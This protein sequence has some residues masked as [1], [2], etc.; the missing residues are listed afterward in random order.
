MRFPTKL[1][2][3]FSGN[4]LV[5]SN[6][7]ENANDALQAEI[8]QRKQTEEALR[9]SEERFRIVAESASDLIYEWDIL[10]GRLD[11][12]GNIDEMLGYAPGEFP[13]T[14][15]V[16]EEIIYPD[17]QD[18]VMT[19][20]DRHLKTK[21][22]FFE[23]YRVLRKDG[24]ILY[25]TDRGKALRDEKGTPYRW[26]GAI[27]NITER[28]QTEEAL[29]ENEEHFRLLAESA[30][31][32]II[33]VD[34]TGRIIFWNKGA[35]DVFGYTAD[36]AL[37]MLFTIVVPERLRERHQ[38]HIENFISRGR[39][40]ILE[41]AIEGIGV[42][43]DGRELFFETSNSLWKTKEGVFLTA[44]IHDI[45]DRK[46][47]ENELKGTKKFLENIF[48][49]T[50]DGIMISDS[51]GYIVRINRALEEMLGFTQ[52]ELIG[53]HTAELAPQTEKQKQIGEKLLTDL[54]EKGFIKNF[55]TAWLRKDGSLCPVELN[56]TMLKDK[57][58]NITEAVSAIRDITERKKME[59]QI[60]RAEKLRSL[61]ELSGGVAHDFNNILAAILGRTQL[62]KR[63]IETTSQEKQIRGDSA[64]DLKNGLEII[65]R[66]ALDGAETV[67]RIQEFSRK[68]DE[69]HG[70]I[71]S[72][73]T[74][75]D[76]NKV[77]NDALEF[78]Q[79]RWKDTAESK[80]IKIGIERNLSSV[81][82]I[83]G[84]ASELREVLTNILNNALDAMPEGGEIRI[85]SLRENNTVKIKIG[86]TGI[87]IPSEIK[88]SIYDPFFTTKGPQ[89]TGLG[90]SVSYGII[91]RHQG[92]IS[93]DTAEGKGTTFTI[94][95][96]V[97]V[98]RDKNESNEESQPVVDILKKAAIL[99]IDDED[100]VRT[101][102]CD[103]LVENGHT[104]EVAGSG[105]EGIELFKKKDFDLVFTD[106]GMPGMSGW[107][108]AE[109]IKKIKRETPVA[110]ITGWKVDQKSEMMKNGVDLIVNKP[111]Q[112]DQVLR[113]VHEGME[114]RKRLGN[115]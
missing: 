14:L 49:T 21:E 44:I 102:L 50:Q 18:R 62:L 13:Q 94:T 88:E 35:E 69:S 58:G 57:E 113:L 61:G 104:V 40:A 24:T 47:A 23:K 66:A 79:S 34:S 108:V 26:I 7:L 19:A 25:W 6:E 38:K 98:T 76:V 89:S 29:R 15:K 81:P 110:L 83:L 42:R 101:L 107:Q 3:L 74:E 17:D 115:N 41:K 54:F 80:G 75:V 5:R 99:V 87:G 73:S 28:K 4:L 11:W 71:Y 16:W 52:E 20:I 2:A 112:L 32:A 96:P 91:N 43:K 51:L 114:I 77:I 53:K 86:D 85:S 31:D 55:E 106:L 8:T 56:I 45:T 95:L 111:F 103:I 46:Q 48:E 60:I 22:P 67:R 84:S 90:M 82:L 36:E 12:L 92:T 27:T 1:S 70:D 68:R 105:S 109:E 63:I 72:Y 100:A 78:T 93:V 59:Y 65:E 64:H 30:S 97:Q 33:T 9:E 39:S 10:N 37:G